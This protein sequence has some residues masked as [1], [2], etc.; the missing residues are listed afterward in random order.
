MLGLAPLGWSQLGAN[1]ADRPV[2]AARGAMLPAIVNDA[3]MELVPLLFRKEP[4]Q[5]AWNGQ[6]LPTTPSFEKSPAINRVMRLRL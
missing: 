6:Q 4:L 1:L 2:A 5:G 3:Q